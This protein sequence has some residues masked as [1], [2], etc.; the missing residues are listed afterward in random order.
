MLQW[1]FYVLVVTTLVA[2]SGWVIEKALR[3]GRSRAVANNPGYGEAMGSARIASIQFKS[4]TKSGV[5][6]YLAINQNGSQTSWVVS[7]N[8]EG[9]I[10]GLGMLPTY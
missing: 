9:K 7:V 2:A 1:V 3:A 8:A 4:I 10:N 6:K 5:D